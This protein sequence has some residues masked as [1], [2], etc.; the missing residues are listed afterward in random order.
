MT[1]TKYTPEKADKM[2]KP[3]ESVRDFNFPSHGV[4]IQASC[5]REAHDKLRKHL[6]PKSK[7]ND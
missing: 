7:T 3:S 1:K 4:T 6:K 2:A 5:T